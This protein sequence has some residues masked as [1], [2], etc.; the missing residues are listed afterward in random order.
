MEKMSMS[1]RGDQE[2]RHEKLR[3]SLGHH[4]YP[5]KKLLLERS[6]SIDT[7]LSFSKGR[8]SVTPCAS[9]ASSSTPS[10]EY[11]PVSSCDVT[12]YAIEMIKCNKRV[13]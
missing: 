1:T 7:K 4:L 12:K 11:F 3:S 5:D 8:R 2:M 10:R 6:Q 13:F 9:R